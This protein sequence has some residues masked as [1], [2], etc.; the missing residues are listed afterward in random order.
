M[1][2]TI[3]LLN[4]KIGNIR[5]YSTYGHE[6][7]IWRQSFIDSTEKA[8]QSEADGDGLSALQAVLARRDHLF[9]ISSEYTTTAPGMRWDTAPASGWEYDW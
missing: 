9:S 1:M 5:H 3:D 7:P 2:I 8:L 6:L 4:R